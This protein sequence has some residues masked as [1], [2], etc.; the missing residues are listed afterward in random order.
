MNEYL[1][2]MLSNFS[3]IIEEKV[4]EC[5]NKFGSHIKLLNS[6]LKEMEAKLHIIQNKTNKIY[7]IFDE[8]LVKSDL[9]M[10]NMAESKLKIEKAIQEINSKVELHNKRFKNQESN[11]LHRSKTLQTSIIR[12]SNHLDIANN[13]LIDITKKERRALN[14]DNLYRQKIDKIVFYRSLK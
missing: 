12:Q 8:I 13:V 14:N 2:K 11:K 3:K 10:K 9:R 1:F 4:S 5:E 6:K 7:G